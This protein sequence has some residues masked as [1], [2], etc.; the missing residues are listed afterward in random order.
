MIG[1]IADYGYLGVFLMIFLEN[2]F[3]PIPSEVILTFG[4]FMAAITR[5]NVAG[6][7]TAATT[8]SLLG[9]AALY[10]LGYKLGQ[11]RL[12]SLVLRW[13]RVLHIRQRDI[14]QS[15]AWFSR[16]QGKTVFFC[17]MVPLIRSL[18]SIPAGISGMPFG[19]FMLLTALGSAIWNT[20]L[21]CA[22]A[23][24]GERW[25]SVLGLLHAYS[26]ATCCLLAVGMVAGFVVLLV[27]RRTAG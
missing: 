5:M 12:E 19:V 26:R 15:L 20:A 6:V 9:A 3:P 8:G 1:I 25:D 14:D 23:A 22:G 16:Y 24:L 10:L 11:K 21:V 13:G 27:R 4:G 7:A 18:I 2:I 17:R